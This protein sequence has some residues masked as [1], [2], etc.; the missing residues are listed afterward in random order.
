MNENVKISRLKLILL[1][2]DLDLLE[3]FGRRNNLYCQNTFFEA[4]K[5]IDAASNI[6]PEML[7]TVLE[8]RIY[9]NLASK[10][11]SIRLSQDLMDKVF[12]PQDESCYVEFRALGG[13]NYQ[14][15]SKE[16]VQGISKFIETMRKSVDPKT[17]ANLYNTIQYYRK[18]YNRKSQIVKSKLVGESLCI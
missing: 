3:Q 12:D 7:K 9:N 16:L 4:I 5:W 17:D 15:K 13:R 10:R 1:H 6:S 14:Y 18:K 2:N 8:R 11:F